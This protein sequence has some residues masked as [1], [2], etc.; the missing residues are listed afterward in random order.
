MRFHN[1]YDHAD[2]RLRRCSFNTRGQCESL[3]EMEEQQYRLSRL[4][5]Y[6]LI[7]NK[8]SIMVK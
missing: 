8:E 3:E 5:F 4:S 6:H 1:K 2:V 7:A